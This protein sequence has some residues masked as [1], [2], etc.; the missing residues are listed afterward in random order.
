MFETLSESFKGAINKLRFSDDEKAL[1][2]ALDQLKKSLLKSDVHFKVV[3]ELIAN[4]ERDT[5]K[6]SI[7]KDNFLKAIEDNLLGVLQ[8]AGHQGFVYAPQGV[9]TVLMMGL[10]GS[11]KTTTSGKL[12]YHLKQ[13]NK[14]VL[15]CACD[16]HRLAA[17]EQLKQIASQIEVD[18]FYDE[19]SQNIA[20]IAKKAKAKATKEQYDVLIID[21]AG[22]IAIDE[23]LMN[24]LITLEKTVQPN[25]K[26]YVA[27]SLTGQ[28]ASKNATIFNEKVGIS[29]V[30]LTKYDGDSKGG[31]AISIAHQVKI[32]LRFIG[33][34]EKMPDLEAFLP[35][36][37]VSRLL[38]QGDIEGLSE[39]ASLV[40]KEQ[41]I[42]KITKKMKKGQFNFND[43]LQQ[44]ENVKKMGSLKSLVSMIPGMDKGL[45]S[46][47]ADL[48]LDNSKE[49]KV[50]KSAINSMTPKERENPDLLMKNNTR[51]RRI[52]NGAGI[53]IIEVNRLLKQMHHASKMAK[54]LS[55]G[56]MK[57]LESMMSQM[58]AGGR[59]R[60]I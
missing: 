26:F 59:P 28:E 19:D 30:I 31:I 51:K 38:G 20:D 40:V 32:P 14:K 27:D 8:T 44:I 55:G 16:L 50:L 21:S 24:E 60:G 9:T 10:Q 29:G 1:K 18:I 2:K 37:I 58:S 15:L 22:R 39:K 41:E 47:I 36:R 23:P 48:D 25:E 42:K 3:K 13:R 35:D 33:S 5:K 4:I 6:S 17:V 49:I 56:N 43:Y 34:G 53:D 11:G 45:K 46:Q 54:K 57:N 7:G 12:A 52:A